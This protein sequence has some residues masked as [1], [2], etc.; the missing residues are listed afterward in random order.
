M[1]RERAQAVRAA[2]HRALAAREKIVRDY[3]QWEEWRQAARALKA[4]AIGRLDEL[5]AR[6]AREVEAWGGE[7]LWAADAGQARRLIVEVAGRHRV[8]SVVKSKS[9]TTEEIGLN[10][11]LAGAGIR[12]TETDLGEFIIQLAG[13]TPGHLTAPALHL[14][15]HQI[16]R[17]FATQLSLE[18][19]PDPEVLSR[20]AS[21]H[22]RPHF[23]RAQMGITGVNFAAAAD[24]TLVF[25]ENESNLRQSASLPPVHLALMGL[26]KV[27]PNLDGLDLLLRLLPASATGQRLTALVHFLRGLKSGPQGRRQAFYLVILDNGR[28]RLA[29]DPELAEALYCLRCGACLNVCPVFQ[30]GAAHLYGRI[31]SGPIGILLA[32]DIAPPGDIADLCT[33]CGAC[34]DI[35][36]VAIRLPEK[37]LYLRRHS[38]RFRGV[39]AISGLAGAV[40][41]RP[42]LYRRLEPG[43]RFLAKLVPG[44]ERRQLFE[45]ALAP[46]SFHRSSKKFL[47]AGGR[48]GE[49][50]AAAAGA[51]PLSFSAPPVPEA[52]PASPVDMD[53]E[54]GKPGG[55]MASPGPLPPPGAGPLLETRLTEAGATLH[56]VRGPTA[57]ARLLAEIATEPLW[58]EEHP[59]L[60]RA[61][62]A[63]AKRGLPPHLG[64]HGPDF[65]ADTAVIVG[66]GAIPETGT[67]LVG[68]PRPPALRARRLIVLVPGARAALTLP[69]ALALTRAQPPGLVTWL[70]GPTRTADIEKILVLGA[71]G[72]GEMAAVIYQDRAP[73]NAPDHETQA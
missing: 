65:Q 68:P 34:G 50:E 67:V 55:T 61:A 32:P 52:R 38:Q 14:N 1:D 43:L 12:T 11:A 41:S 73:Q 59:W 69:E 27:L 17:I 16:A 49:V 4:E 57:L 46:E 15:R 51:A 5:A 10:H 29:A 2:T 64:E 72:P 31:Y 63:L 24:G 7:V 58:L 9:M 8:E 56:L 54:K 71:Q 30:V 35:C 44:A 13:D 48:V 18:C 28:R 39:R 42:L 3:P 66:L 36:P 33:Q 60:N 70:T 6:L 47:A 25:I 62:S 26:E 40:L 19:P 23:G 22:L 37:I 53:G 20:E 45:A 21:L